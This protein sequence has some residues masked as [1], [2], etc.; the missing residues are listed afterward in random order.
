MPGFVSPDARDHQPRGVLLGGLLV[1]HNFRLR[2]VFYV[3]PASK[4]IRSESRRGEARRGEARVSATT[5]AASATMPGP[6]R[7]VRSLT[8]PRPGTRSKNSHVKL[9]Q[10]KPLCGCGFEVYVI[11][12]LLE[13]YSLSHALQFAMVATSAHS[14]SSSSLGRSLGRSR[15]VRV[16]PLPFRVCFAPVSETAIDRGRMKNL[17]GCLW[18]RWVRVRMEDQKRE[19][20]IGSASQA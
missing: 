1:L 5:A 9:H 13:A 17:V 18:G 4:R 15:A 19:N 3:P 16:P 8:H 12:P 11:S 6:G 20:R 10:F 14:L 2:L 7:R